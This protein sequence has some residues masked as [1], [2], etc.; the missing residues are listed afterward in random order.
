M[1][2]SSPRVRPSSARRV[3]L[4]RSGGRRIKFWIA[5]AV[6]LHAELLLLVGVGLYLY[7]PRNADLARNLPADES[8]SIDV[9]M[10]DDEAAREIIADLEKQDEARKA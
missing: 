6:L 10:V 9:G 7:A 5:V 4:H 2:V 8:P 1:P 3:G